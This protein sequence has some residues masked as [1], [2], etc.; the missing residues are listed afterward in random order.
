MKRLLFLISFA[1]ISLSSNA[2]TT[3]DDET[4]LLYYKEFFFGGGLQTEGWNLT[5]DHGK[6]KDYHNTKLWEVE[7][8]SLHDPRQF[9]Q[10]SAFLQ[11]GP[12]FITPNSYVFGKQNNFFVIN[13]SIG[14]QRLI[15]EKAPKSGVEVSIRYLGG[16]SLGILKPY[17]LDLLYP[18]DTLQDFQIESQPYS[19][20][21]AAKFLDPNY[22]FGASS[23]TYGL[24]QLSFVPGINAKLALN[25][26]WAP[27]DQFL[28][29]LE[30]GI[31]FQAYIK[32]IPIMLQAPNT[33]FFPNLF[34]NVQLGKKS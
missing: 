27:E 9:K 33:Q 26:Q 1:I 22:I 17:Y 29:A 14:G 32:K 18:V 2:Q 10:T 25:F 16:L 34:V 20:S 11:S 12:F 15:G 31:T 28:K 21:N 7:F 13:G 8:L 6:I 23:F 30:V 4:S 5:F 24:N 19:A 3:A